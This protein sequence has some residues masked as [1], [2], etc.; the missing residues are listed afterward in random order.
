MLIDVSYLGN[1]GNLKLKRNNALQVPLSSSA[2][3][4]VYFENQRING[5]TYQTSS[6]GLARSIARDNTGLLQH[7]VVLEGDRLEDDVELKERSELSLSSTRRNYSE[8]VD[9]TFQFGVDAVSEE[10]PLL[11]ACW[12]NF[13]QVFNILTSPVITMVLRNDNR[14]QVVTRDGPSSNY[15][16]Q[17]LYTTDNFQR[18]VWYNCR[19]RYRVNPNS[20]SGLGFLEL[21]LWK[22]GE[23]PEKIVD[24][25]G[26]IGYS[27][28]TE[29][30]EKFGIYRSQTSPIKMG[31]WFSNMNFSSDQSDFLLNPPNPI[32]EGSY[33]DMMTIDLLGQY[34]SSEDLSTYN[35]NSIPLGLEKNDRQICIALAFGAATSADV[36]GISIQPIDQNGLNLGNPISF[37]IS[38][39]TPGTPSTSRALVA[40]A[41]VPAGITGKIVINSDSPL[42]RIGLGVFRVQGCINKTSLGSGNGRF[43]YQS[44]VM[45]VT[46]LRMPTS[47]S[48]FWGISRI[49]TSDAQA[50][51]SGATK[52]GTDMSVESM[53]FSLSYGKLVQGGDPFPVEV[54][55][56]K[57]GGGPR[58]VMGALW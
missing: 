23:Q 15:N 56:S 44:I 53:S 30:Y 45:P 40:T 5:V 17:Y 57:S 31:T 42:G 49:E 22:Y 54:S 2:P 51:W 13:G 19:R 6:A 16:T 21:W 41:D 38:Y 48:V 34:S 7:F 33:Q 9:Q 58:T 47:P 27:D 18:G 35:F 14:L 3:Y 36:T 26:P 8:I 11:G 28:A 32:P 10:Y 46:T 37:S 52:V 29:Y 55:W 50:T 39:K 1:L 43:F 4:P 24:Y 25:V 20:E 12:V